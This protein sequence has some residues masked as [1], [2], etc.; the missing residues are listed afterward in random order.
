[1]PAFAR[2]GKNACAASSAVGAATRNAIGQTAGTDFAG[3]GRGE[4]SAARG[5]IRWANSKLSEPLAGKRIVV[6]RAPEQA[7]ELVR[8]LE[9]AGS[10]SAAA[11][12]GGVCAAGRLGRRGSKRLARLAE[13]DWILF[14]SQNAVRFF[15]QRLQGTGEF[16]ELRTV[17][18]PKVAARGAGDGGDGEAGRFSRGLRGQKLQR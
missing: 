1:M 9:A 11:A 8:S 3:G 2:T 14:T 17:D 5:K 6:T 16:G 18:A 12:D 4:D 13:F 7:G 15:A 10:G